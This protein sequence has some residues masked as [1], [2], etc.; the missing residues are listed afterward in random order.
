M[1]S[2]SLLGALLVSAAVAA[3][4][5]TRPPDA[6]GAKLLHDP[7]DLRPQAPLPPDAIVPGDA[8][9]AEIVCEADAVVAAGTAAVPAPPVARPTIRIAAPWTA[10]P[11]MTG[12][13]GSLA[14]RF[15]KRGRTLIFDGGSEV[16]YLDRDRRRFTY[17]QTR[18]G[19]VTTL[20][21]LCHAED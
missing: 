17:A 14:V 12:P 1:N 2:R 9:V 11:V 6:G 3:S 13:S 21:G 5:E 10:A 18:R 16:L 8:A 20:H 15:L 7:A 4:A 19:T